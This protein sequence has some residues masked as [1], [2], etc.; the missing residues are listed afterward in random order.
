MILTGPEI[1]KR[2]ESGEIVI[3]D[4][5][6]KQL[7][8]NSYNLRLHNELLVYDNRVADMKKPSETSRIII[9]EDGFVIYP[10]EFY[11]GRTTEFTGVSGNIVPMLEGRSSIAR[12]SILVHHAAGFGDL[13]FGYPT[14]CPW[15]LEISTLIPI[16]I[17]PNV[18]ICQIYYHTALGEITP[19]QGKYQGN[20]DIQA[21]MLYKDFYK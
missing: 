12:F 20:N 17:Y 14:P 7:G 18:E 19:Y 4:F 1:K 13:M 5:N 10:G 16:R 11:L 15:T 21:S 3:S 8:P 6:E 2:V 9:P